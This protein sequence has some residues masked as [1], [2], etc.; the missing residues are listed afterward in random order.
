MPTR[1][2]GS[3][4]AGAGAHGGG[5]PSGLPSCGGACGGGEGKRRGAAPSKQAT[6]VVSG[7]G[8]ATPRGGDGKKSGLVEGLVREVTG[9]GICRY[10]KYLAHGDYERGKCCTMMRASSQR[11]KRN[12]LLPVTG[13]AKQPVLL[14]ARYGIQID[15]VRRQQEKEVSWILPMFKR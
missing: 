6:E 12:N 13:N 9:N 5:Q 3:R 15:G 10:H 2:R 1:A 4:H 11:Q 14:C 8:W 7:H